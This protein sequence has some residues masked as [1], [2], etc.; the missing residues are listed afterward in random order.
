MATR[1]S[2]VIKASDDL[3][4]EMWPSGGAGDP[5]LLKVK[6]LAAERDGEDQHVVVFLN[7]VGSLIV[8]LGEAAA[9]L[10]AYE[11]AAARAA[12]EGESDGGK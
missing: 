11:V 7:E 4:V 1:A 2:S 6:N 5:A 3:V 12:C 10:A 8:A 9:N